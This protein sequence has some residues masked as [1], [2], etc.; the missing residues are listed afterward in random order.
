MI[1]IVDKN[2]AKIRR[3]LSQYEGPVKEDEL[4]VKVTDQEM[5][6][7]FYQG[8]ELLWDFKQ[9]RV[10]VEPI[11]EFKINIDKQAIRA[12][13]KDPATITAIIPDGIQKAYVF[14]NGFPVGEEQVIDNQISI[15]VSAAPQEAGFHKVEVF[16]GQHQG[17]FI[18]QALEE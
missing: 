14:V 6:D 1:V 9:E 10:Y 8:K 3:V 11:K 4:K 16:A 13:D 5:V 2:K 12:N 18:I 17:V 15:E 7:A